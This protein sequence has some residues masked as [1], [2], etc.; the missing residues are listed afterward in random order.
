[1]A[2]TSSSPVR[3]KDVVIR[4]STDGGLT[5]PIVLASRTP[6]DGSEPVTVPN[7][8]TNAARIKVEAIGNIFFNISKANLTI[9]AGVDCSFSAGPINQEFNS[10]ASN[11]SVNVM[12][13]EECS[14]IVSNVPS[15]IIITSGDS[16]SGSGVVNYSVTAN[17]GTSRTGAMT[18]AGQ[19]VFVTQAAAD[20][21]IISATVSGKK[22]LISGE[23]FDEGAAILLNGEKQ[24]TV[25]ND[26][27]PN[28]KL[29]A[30]KSGKKIKAD[31]KLQVRNADG[32]LSQ[33][34]IFT[35]S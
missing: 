33:E 30:R 26:A 23:G 31:D 4:L 29:V 15:W 5:F 9:A 16:G 11:G 34:F 19:I 3:C 17:T 25:N 7:I 32:R 35:G 13:T 20:P 22:L 24:K 14:W 2:N 18:I 6:N 28:T 1:V 8:P 27:D 21:K 12:T 10:T